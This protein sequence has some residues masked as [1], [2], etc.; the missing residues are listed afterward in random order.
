MQHINYRTTSGLQYHC[1]SWLLS[2]SESECPTADEV[3]AVFTKLGMAQV[4]DCSV[5]C[6]A[7]ITKHSEDA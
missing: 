5:D 6:C 2:S 7:S 1:S 3:P 4:I